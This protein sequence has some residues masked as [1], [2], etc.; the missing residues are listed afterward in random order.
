QCNEFVQQNYGAIQQFQG[1]QH[2]SSHITNTPL[3]MSSSQN[4]N[5][6]FYRNQAS[7]PEIQ[8]KPLFVPLTQQLPAQPVP[9]VLN[10]SAPPPGWIKVNSPPKFAQVP[11]HTP[12]VPNILNHHS[13]ASGLNTS[14][15]KSKD[16]LDIHARR[17]ASDF[18]SNI[19]SKDT[20]IDFENENDCTIVL[21]YDD[22][23][24]DDMIDHFIKDY[25]SVDEKNVSVVIDNLGYDPLDNPLIADDSLYSQVMSIFFAVDQQNE[26]NFLISNVGSPET[27]ILQQSKHTKNIIPQPQ[28]IHSASIPI[29]VEENQQLSSSYSG[30]SI[31]GLVP[32]QQSSFISSQDLIEQDF[33]QLPQ[34]RQPSDHSQR[35]PVVISLRQN[36]IS[37]HQ[38]PQPL[39]STSLNPQTTN[40]GNQNP[41]VPRIALLSA[42]QSSRLTN[43][44][45]KYQLVSPSPQ[46]P[47]R[48]PHEFCHHSNQELSYT[49]QNV[50]IPYQSTQLLGIQPEQK[51]TLSEISLSPLNVPPLPKLRFNHLG[52]N[53]I[54]QERKFNQISGKNDNQQRSTVDLQTI[55]QKREEV[56][57]NGT[58]QDQFDFAMLLL[59]T[60]NGIFFF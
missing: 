55:N 49:N 31:Q 50:Q 46:Q 2:V 7:I 16:Y 20:I 27:Q 30:M 3:M 6:M 18:V 4:P 8:Q 21:D 52:R 53:Q 24:D 23:D 34:F 1:Q 19:N 11:L 45:L 33:Q 35:P 40:H 37:L 28:I 48:L 25:E 32:R 22:D 58:P 56:K 39:Q 26:S 43:D 42:P 13:S 10:S 60:S 54:N 36:F 15:G 51:P 14:S 59:Q 47:I 5:K 44:Q 17:N 12:S 38:Q 57:K 9:L 41:L 29:T